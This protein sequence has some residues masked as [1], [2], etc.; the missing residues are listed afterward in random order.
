MA[1]TF[2]HHPVLGG[3]LSPG[4]ELRLFSQGQ[5]GLGVVS[6]HFVQPDALG[7]DQNAARPFFLALG[8]GGSHSSWSSLQR[9]RG[10]RGGRSQPLP[11]SGLSS[12][13]FFSPE[14]MLSFTTRWCYCPI[15]TGLGRSP[16]G[17]PPLPPPSTS[18]SCFYN[19]VKVPGLLCLG[20]LSTFPAGPT[21]PLRSSLVVQCL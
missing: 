19:S 1:F 20:P 14:V 10:G 16:G 4:K 9:G 13:F 2:V 18:C 17:S 11:S 7:R 5:V 12:V 6:S 15:G 8:R 3:R 21:F